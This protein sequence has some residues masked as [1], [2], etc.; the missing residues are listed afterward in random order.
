MPSR[1]ESPVRW[2]V[3]GPGHAGTRFAE[4]LQAVPEASLLAVYGRSAERTEAYAQRFAV[5][6]VCASLEDLLAASLDAVYV[7]TLT[8]THSQICIQA[9]SAGKHVMCEKPAALNSQQLKGVLAAARRSG[10]LFM[11]AMKPP[12]FPLYRKLRDHLK[13]DPIGHVG[14]VRAGH[15]DSVRAPHY[16]VN[17]PE[18]AGGGIM[19][20]GPYEAFLALDWLGDLKRIQIMGRLNKAGVDNLALIQTEHEHGMAQLHTGL[21]LLSRGDALLSAPGGC[22]LI[23]PNWWNPERATITYADGHIVELI[24]PYSHG[25]FNYETVHFGELIRH[26]IL[27]S[28]VISHALSLAMAHLLE[29]S[30]KELGVRFPGE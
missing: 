2:G 1:D 8:D 17:L 7:A 27:E 30:R 21:D 24:E 18:Q 9:L 14:F 4:G 6:K 12:F 15:A 19:A 28:P 26:G 23:H 10:R 25:G 20:M 29:T 3:V 16:P 22:V 11:E 5:P 13:I